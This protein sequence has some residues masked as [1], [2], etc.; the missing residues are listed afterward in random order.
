ML[1]NLTITILSKD[2]TLTKFLLLMPQLFLKE[3]LY[4]IIKGILFG[5]ET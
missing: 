3:H 1:I 2:L 4:L 5:T